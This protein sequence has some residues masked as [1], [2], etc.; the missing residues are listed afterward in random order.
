MKKLIVIGGATASGKTDFAIRL[1]QYFKTSIISADSRQFYREMSIGTAKPTAAELAAA[2]HFFVNNRSIHE[3]YSV[4]D[5]EREA[6]AILATVFEKNE[7]AVMVGGTGLYLKA[8][9][10]G[11]DVFPDTPL[12]IRQ[13]FEAIFEKQGIAPL[14]NLLQNVD[15]QYFNQVDQHNPARLIRALSVWKVSGQ[16]YSSFLSAPKAERFFEPIYI[17]LDLPRAVLYDRINRRVDAMVAAGL[18]EEARDLFPYR[19]LQALQT[20]GYAELFEHFLGNCTLETAID[21][22]KQHSRN[23]AKR[24][25]TWLR[26]EVHW[27]WLSPDDTEGAVLNIEYRTRNV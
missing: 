4:G 27:H 18:V 3:P 17:A 15:L 14:Q 11:L 13:E 12:S 5:F 9:C 2:P 6:L 22:I 24:Q 1:A 23:Y 16:P 20:V 19:H 25:L 21:K 10:D 26:K 8:V 7:V